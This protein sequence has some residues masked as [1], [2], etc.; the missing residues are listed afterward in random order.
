MDI[1][2]VLLAAGYTAIDRIV[3][4]E[5]IRNLPCP[6]VEHKN[7][8]RH[9]GPSM[10]YPPTEE[11]RG[12][13]TCRNCNENWGA[14][15]LANALGVTGEVLAGRERYVPPRRSTI[16]REK[17][18]Q[19]VEPINMNEAWIKAQATTP[20]SRNAFNY[21]KRRWHN[22]DCAEEA[23]QFVGWT[24]G[25]KTDYWKKYPGHLLLVPLRDKDGSVVSGVRRF[26][27]HGNT[28][29]KS[30]RI[31]NE[32]VGLASGTPVWFGDPP[33]AAAKYAAGSTL[34]IAEGE[35]DTL[36]LMSLRENNK[37]EGGI[38]GAAG[39]SAA[40]PK[41]WDETAKLIADPPT[42][43]VIV[44]DADSAG[45]KYWQKSAT[46]FPNAQRVFLPDGNDLTDTMKKFGVEEVLSLLAASRSAHFRFYQL[47]SGQFAYLS[48]DVWY[49]GS[50]RNSLTARLRSS[51]YDYEEAK[52]MST[53]LPPARDIAF[54][55]SS[56]EPV[57]VRRNNVWLNQF[58]GLP[59]EPMPGDYTLYTD[60]LYWLCGEDE[61]SFE[62]SMDWIAKPLQS[63]YTGKGAHRNKS[64]LIFYGEQGSGKGMFWGPD[65]MMR[66]IYGRRQTEILQ[67]QMDDS[68]D[69][70]SM[71]T[72]LMLVANEVACS[73]YRDS[74]TLNKLKAWI[75]EPTIQVRRMRRTAEEMPIWFNMV[76]MSNDDTPIRLEPGDRRYSVFRQEKKLSPGRITDLVRERD[77]GWPGAV[78]FL[79]ALL[80]RKVGADLAVPVAN[81]ARLTLLDASKPSQIS[82]AEL[83]AEFGLNAVMKDWVEAMGEK[84][85]GPFTDAA[86]GFV[87]GEHLME[88]Y[89]FW[90]RQ[91]GINYPVRM[92]T[93][94]RALELVMPEMKKT[95]GRLG[96]RRVRG[97]AN[98]P[99]GPGGERVKPVKQAI[100]FYDQ[101]K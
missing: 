10:I 48:G 32:A 22:D 68:F 53:N 37:I 75:T 67:T 7:Q 63:L 84:R 66:A 17:E 47:D 5:P 56:T 11:D 82:F 45:D 61:N 64:A 25:H 31:S 71:T 38:L 95:Q 94:Y 88:V 21:F 86:T 101:V 40:T 50:G 54:D 36:L 29:V 80:K 20:H 92:P 39:G 69:H 1:R 28:S 8:G 4:S 30:L 91:T 55:P 34:Y 3:G 46:A 99:M 14:R 89:R 58:R 26:T 76:F 60:L 87:S 16:R 100:P 12:T 27:G 42:S 59:L 93:L 65:G 24:S 78:C 77:S 19:P 2:E 70:K 23:L 79:D 18:K 52:A 51:G 90:C 35:I 81:K 83:I 9:H 41:W 62:Y 57:V 96:N 43:V 74:K 97:I 98:L 6:V 44:M 72:V 13:L 73:G 49:T 85:A 33:P 15:K